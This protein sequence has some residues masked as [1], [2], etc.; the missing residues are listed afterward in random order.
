MQAEEPSDRINKKQRKVHKAAFRLFFI[1]QV[2][3][4]QGLKWHF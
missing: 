4:L 3:I 1:L 2:I